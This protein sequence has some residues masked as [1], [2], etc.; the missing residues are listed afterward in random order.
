MMSRTGAVKDDL[1]P[2]GS[3]FG[4]HAFSGGG[5]ES[6]LVTED[7]LRRVLL[8]G[9]GVTVALVALQAIAQAIDFGV[10]DLR[11]R[12]LNSDH[13]GSLFGIVSLLAQL[14]VAAVSAWRGAGAKRHRWAWLTL[15]GIAAV[16]VFI[17]GLTTY[18]ATALAL[19]LACLLGL[20]VWLTWTDPR[21]A[22]RF[23]WAG[24]VLMVVSLLLHHVGLDADSSTASDY[25]WAYQITGMIKHGAE[26]AGW[27][28]VAT[29]LI[30]GA[31]RR[32]PA[33]DAITGPDGVG[34]CPV[35]P[36]PADLV[37]RG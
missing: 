25:T 36:G 23:V 10:F 31:P 27:M 37:R 22:R 32:A 28:L 7:A 5:P 14:A 26:L 35:T 6:R 13:H 12:S 34:R 11:L 30:A 29:G 9:L 15:A 17:R 4:G 21:R 24:L 16:L 20:L 19:P 18:N 3:A 8:I 2:P 1:A 33:A